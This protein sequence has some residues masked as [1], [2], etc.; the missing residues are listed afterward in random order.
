MET[1][2]PTFDHMVSVSW[3]AITDSV[4]SALF[5]QESRAS[6][7]REAARVRSGKPLPSQPRH[8]ASNDDEPN[9][10]MNGKLIRIF[11]DDK[12]HSNYRRMTD[13]E[14]KAAYYVEN[15]VKILRDIARAEAGIP[16]PT[17]P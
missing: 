6:I 10:T 4:K 5:Y 17:K 12:V 1:I 2:D 15:S 7:E 14:E 16:V 13:P 8:P 11:L 9:S 3:R